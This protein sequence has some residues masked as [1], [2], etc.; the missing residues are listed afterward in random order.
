MTELPDDVVD[1]AER[2]TRLARD[3]TGEEAQ[4]HRQRRAELL[5]EHGYRAR[6][7]EA[8]ETLVLYPED[9]VTEGRVDTGEIEDTGRA[10]ECSLS[11]SGE[12]AA[13]AE[14][15]RG[16]AREV[17]LE[18]GGVH[19]ENATA[20]V[21]YMNNHHA[22]RIERAGDREIE[23]FLEG[24]FPRNAWPSDAQREAVEASLRLV[25]EVAGAEV[26]PAIRQSR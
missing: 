19:G 12:W 3:A 17:A 25:F 6:V 21:E 13:V 8:D 15:N 23:E 16:V 11:A 2:L 24:Y 22:R 5:A 10:T 7:R 9:W 14:H 20:F 26:P 18:H 1:E 4:A